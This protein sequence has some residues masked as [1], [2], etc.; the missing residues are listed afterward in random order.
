MSRKSVVTGIII[1]LAVPM[2]MYLAII[3]ITNIGDV[4]GNPEDFQYHDSYFVVIHIDPY[5]YP[6][7]FLITFMF[8]AAIFLIVRYVKRK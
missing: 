6:V 8:Y 2:I 5:V 1:S 3:G 4:S 7:L